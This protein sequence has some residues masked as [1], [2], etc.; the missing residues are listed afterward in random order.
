M[1]SVDQGITLSS[2]RMDAERKDMEFRSDSIKLLNIDD[3][4]DDEDVSHHNFRLSSILSSTLISLLYIP[5]R[6]S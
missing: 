1:L 2:V 6:K 3:D 4:D 5:V